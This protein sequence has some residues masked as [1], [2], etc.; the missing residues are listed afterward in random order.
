MYTAREEKRINWL[1]LP[2]QG[3]TACLRKLKREM[4]KVEEKQ[5]KEELRCQQLTL[6][7]DTRNSLNFS[8]KQTNTENWAQA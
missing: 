5:G 8:L 2:E 6:K 7:A 3:E 4:H 1:F